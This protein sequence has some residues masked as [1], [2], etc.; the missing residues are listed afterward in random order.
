MDRPEEIIIP[1]AVNAMIF[2]TLMLWIIAHYGLSAWK[3][4]RT[5]SLIR[6]MVARGY[7]AA[8]IIQIC[9]ALGH[10]KPCLDPK[11]VMDVP[12]A[13]PIQQPAFSP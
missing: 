8:E 5:T 13:K 4:W 1:V 3:H 9:Q 10:K 7:T 11:K 6:D 12:P 2:G